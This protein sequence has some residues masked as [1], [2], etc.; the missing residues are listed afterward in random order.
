MMASELQNE[1]QVFQ[2]SQFLKLL[3]TRN[4]EKQLVV[5][6]GSSFKKV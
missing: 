5:I 3:N 1:Q 2:A 4:I 6:V